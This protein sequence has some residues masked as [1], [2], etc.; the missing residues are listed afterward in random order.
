LVGSPP[1][2]GLI[3]QRHLRHDRGLTSDALARQTADD[4]DSADEAMAAH[5]QEG[6]AV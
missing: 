4:G 1:E 6:E 3:A 5:D 2:Q